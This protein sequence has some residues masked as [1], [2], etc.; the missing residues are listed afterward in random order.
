L[1]ATGLL[2]VA[3]LQAELTRLQHQNHKLQRINAR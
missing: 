3:E 2:S 1:P